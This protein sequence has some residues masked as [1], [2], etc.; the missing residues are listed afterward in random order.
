MGSGESWQEGLLARP[1]YA[2]A[3][4]DALGAA[5]LLLSATGQVLACNRG[6]ARILGIDAREACERGAWELLLAAG[7]GGVRESD[8]V[9]EA[10]AQRRMSWSMVAVAEG[11]VLLSGIDVTRCRRAAAALQRDSG[12]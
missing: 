2:A 9:N 11:E 10:V 6:A 1:G 3:I 4:V 5:A 7:T 12:Q 8:W